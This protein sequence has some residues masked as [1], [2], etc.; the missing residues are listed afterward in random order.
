MRLENVAFVKAVVEER[1]MIEKEFEENANCASYV[2]PAGF[3][4][5]VQLAVNVVSATLDTGAGKT[6]CV[7]VRVEPKNT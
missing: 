5:S 6:F 1:S 3:I 2:V 4:P 7:F